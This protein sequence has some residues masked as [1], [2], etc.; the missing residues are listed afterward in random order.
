VHA[1]KIVVAVVMD[2]IAA[3]IKFV[4]A[5]IMENLFIDLILVKINV[6]V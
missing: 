6:V 2:V 3:V 5:Q 4:N 1:I